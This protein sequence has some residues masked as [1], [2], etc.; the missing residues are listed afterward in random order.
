MTMTMMI[1]TMT[2][3]MIIMAIIITITIITIISIHLSS[4]VGRIR[5][6]H[7]VDHSSASSLT[8]QRGRCAWQGTQLHWD[9]NLFYGGDKAPMADELCVQVCFSGDRHPSPLLSSPL[10]SAPLSLL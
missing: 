6:D 3:M 10:F 7:F 9:M 4:H 2:M 8:C 1:M 5:F